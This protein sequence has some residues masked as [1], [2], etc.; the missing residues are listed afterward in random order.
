[1]ALRILIGRPQARIYWNFS[2]DDFEWIIR[3][4]PSLVNK[5]V[6]LVLVQFEL[7]MGR[8]RLKNLLLSPG[9][10]RL[11]YEV[12]KYSVALFRGLSLDFTSGKAP[13]KGGKTF[14]L[15]FGPRR[16]RLG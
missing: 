11:G 15:L 12:F 14:S 7:R 3:L 2:S 5:V 8:V 13:L 4:T 10:L 16:K 9:V 1:M 6:D